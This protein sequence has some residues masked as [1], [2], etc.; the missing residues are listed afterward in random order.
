MNIIYGNLLYT[1][2]GRI[3][4]GWFGMPWAAGSHVMDDFGNSVQVDNDSVRIYLIQNH[5]CN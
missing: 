1:N 2:Y 5:Y 4:H 3:V